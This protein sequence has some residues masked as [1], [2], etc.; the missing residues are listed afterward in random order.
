MA[1]FTAPCCQAKGGEPASCANANVGREIA[2]AAN[3]AAR[4]KLRI[5]RTDLQKAHYSAIAR[6]DHAF[7]CHDSNVKKF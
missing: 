4:P 3:K 1:A 2:L 6:D 7:L 5:D